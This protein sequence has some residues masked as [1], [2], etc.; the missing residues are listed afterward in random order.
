MSNIKISSLNQPASPFPGNTSTPLPDVFVVPDGS[1]GS[2]GRKLKAED[3]MDLYKHLLKDPSYDVR[4]HVQLMRADPYLNTYADIS[5]IGASMSSKEFFSKLD[6]AT[7]KLIENSPYAEI[8]K[9]VDPIAELADGDA[10]LSPK[11]GVMTRFVV[12]NLVQKLGKKISDFNQSIVQETNSTKN[13]TQALD[14]LQSQPKDSA[15]LPASFLQLIADHPSL[16]PVSLPSGGVKSVVKNM[17]VTSTDAFDTKGHRG[18]FGV[19]TQAYLQLQKYAHGT[20]A[21]DKRTAQEHLS[22][23]FSVVPDPKRPAPLTF[24]QYTNLVSKT[25]SL[26]SQITSQSPLLPKHVN[27]LTEQQDRMYQLWSNIIQTL[28]QISGQIVRYEP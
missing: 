10:V 19:S 2:V 26:L 12:G 8:A 18:E 7:K 20:N 25:Q 16:N 6:Q 3:V 28:A 9:G 1:G 13:L 24:D 23:S 5:D 15:M 27:D 4:K 11:I 22:G 21:Q 17:V 14:A